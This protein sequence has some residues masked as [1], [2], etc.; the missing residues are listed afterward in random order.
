MPFVYLLN[1]LVVG[2]GD[3]VA[4]DLR[5]HKLGLARKS[6]FS[7]Q[8]NNRVLQGHALKN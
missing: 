5:K 2:Q 8:K 1:Q 3:A 4:V 6:K 7:L